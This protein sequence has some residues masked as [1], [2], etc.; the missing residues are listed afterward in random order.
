[1]THFSD[2]IQAGSLGGIHFGPQPN[3]TEC[4]YVVVP[5]A[6]SP[7]GVALTQSLASAGTAAL[8][9]ARVTNGTAVLDV[10]R[11][12]TITSAGNAS[13]ITFTVVGSDLYGRQVTQT[14]AGGNVGAATTTK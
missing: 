9:G 5:I 3:C 12:V 14:V 7:N 4:T 2:G 13:G 10:P 6:L 8:N 1:M 11:R